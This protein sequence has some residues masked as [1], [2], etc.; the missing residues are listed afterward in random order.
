ML[1]EPKTREISEKYAASYREYCESKGWTIK[2]DRN[3]VYVLM[4]TFSHL[5]IKQMAMSSGYSSSA[6]RERI[7]FDDKMAGVC[8]IQ[9][10]PTRKA[11][12]EVSWNSVRQNR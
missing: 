4:H 12:S 10:A 3:A 1:I 11:L 5:L 7:Y 9:E 2:A 8:S 6:I